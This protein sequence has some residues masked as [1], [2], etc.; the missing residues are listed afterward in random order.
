MPR[1]KVAV[2]QNPAT[3]SYQVIG[4][5]VYKHIPNITNE[6]ENSKPP[7]LRPIVWRLQNTN[8]NDTN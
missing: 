7:N 5:E 4:L 2:Q 3:K 6:F 8:L 1:S